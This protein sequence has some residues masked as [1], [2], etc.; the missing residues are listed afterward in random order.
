MGQRERQPQNQYSPIPEEHKGRQIYIFDLS[1][2][3]PS[4]FIKG[5]A[6][7]YAPH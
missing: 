7:N 2:P 1:F 3:S 6:I 5:A 4:Y